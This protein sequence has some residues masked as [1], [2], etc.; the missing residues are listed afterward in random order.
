ME[1]LSIDKIAKWQ[2]Q[3][4][5]DENCNNKSGGRQSYFVHDAKTFVAMRIQNA[6]AA[7]R[8]RTIRRDYFN[9]L[10]SAIVRD[11]HSVK[12]YIPVAHFLSKLE[13]YALPQSMLHS[14]KR[15]KNEGF[16]EQ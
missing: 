6:E 9:A 2:V 10:R 15:Q 7:A 12:P 8:I 16:H 1:T 13:S 14:V 4:C 11:L 3:A 5:V